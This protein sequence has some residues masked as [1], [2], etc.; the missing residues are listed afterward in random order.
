MKKLILFLVLSFSAG[1]VSAQ[2]V[3]LSTYYPSPFGMYD[4]LRLVPRAE[5]L[6]GCAGDEGTLYVRNTDTSL[7]FCGAGGAWGAFGGGV[8]TQ[9]GTNLYPTDTATANVGIGTT[10]P[11][12]RLTVNGVLGATGNAF[13]EG[14]LN[15]LGGPTAHNDSGM[16][17]YAWSNQ[18][19]HAFLQG[20]GDSF[21]Y[22]ALSLS[23]GSATPRYWQIRHAQAADFLNKL[24]FAYTPDNGG[25]WSYAMTIDT[26]GNVGIGTT[27]PQ[28]KFHI[29]VNNNTN[30]SSNLGDDFIVGAE[31]GVGIGTTP[32]GGPGGVALY[33]KESGVE[34][35]ARIVLQRSST[36]KYLG[37]DFRR[38]TGATE[39]SLMPS[40]EGGGSPGNFEIWEGGSFRRFVIKKTAG[41]VGIG[42]ADPGTNKLEV[43][44]G[45]I[46][47]TG[48]LIIQTCAGSGGD[49]CPASP[50]NGQMWLCTD[51]GDA[52]PCN[53][54]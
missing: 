44:G 42:T 49:P 15:I 12:D 36:A 25:S 27:T 51:I 39:W 29:D 17:I 37:I 7:R 10:T 33:I 13:I 30:G 48:G 19:A 21:S 32:L 5:L 53:G 50:A 24:N 3:Q 40:I 16:S 6:G 41:N 1:G 45:P 28:A 31:G 38:E 4:R 52:T 11:A 2:S 47:A 14:N 46:K 20:A 22:A 34:R 43:A 23:D 26:T 18:A 54:I 9:N 35:L 8:W